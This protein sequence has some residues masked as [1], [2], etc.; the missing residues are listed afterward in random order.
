MST[1][2]QQLTALNNLQKRRSVMNPK[3]PLKYE[4]WQV[5]TPGGDAKL[6][7][8]GSALKLYRAS[9]SDQTKVALFQALD[10]WRNT[11]DANWK[12]SIGADAVQEL[13]VELEQEARRL[14]QNEPE[15][16]FKKILEKYKPLKFE[17]RPSFL[18]KLK[19]QKW[20]V[21][22]D[23]AVKSVCAAGREMKPDKTS[24]TSASNDLI[25]IFLQ[26]IIAGVGGIGPDI[27][28]EVLNEL[29]SVLGP[30][31]A[32]QVTKVLV[33]CVPFASAFKEAG[34]T[35]LDL[36]STI[37]KEIVAQ[38]IGEHKLASD[39]PQ[40]AIEAMIKVMDEEKK[41]D[42]IS[43]S[44]GIADTCAAILFALHPAAT[45]A[46]AVQEAVSSLCKLGN[47][48]RIIAR[49]I[50]EKRDANALLSKEDINIKAAFETCPVLGAY[51]VCCVPT[52]VLVNRIF[53][54]L[55]KGYSLGRVDQ[56]QIKKVVD[57]PLRQK[58]YELVHAYRFY[59]P[60]LER[61]PGVV[62]PNYQIVE[63]PFQF[64]VLDYIGGSAG[65]A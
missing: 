57:G 9:P 19:T 16:V 38:K 31:I 21:K 3:P 62:S 41:D 49:D 32:T 11:K 13:Y 27:E 51:Y 17:S 53:D 18:A 14:V 34:S 63:N 59:I 55:E 42:G 29:G 15:I 24:A 4:D 40:A 5:L 8:V 52:S 28:K 46:K 36:K 1:G 64:L 26:K 25:K 43:T 30:M 33:A 54:S 58:A 12:A 37:Q 56:D 61:F 23:S 2:S 47:V 45:V 44:N 22:A 50:I 20:L 10:A 35:L 60:K 7:A 65:G 39:T 6:Q 48:A